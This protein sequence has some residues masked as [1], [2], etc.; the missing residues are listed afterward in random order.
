MTAPFNTVYADGG[1]PITGDGL[2]TFVQVCTN[3]AVARNFIGTQG[4]AMALLGTTNPGDGGSGTFYWNPTGTAADDNGTSTIVPSGSSPG[5]GEWT[6][7]T[8]GTAVSI[9][10][11][12]NIT[13][14]GTITGGHLVSTNDVVANDIAINSLG[15]LYFNGPVTGDGTAFPRI[16][17]NA[18]NMTFQLGSGNGQFTFFN[19]SGVAAAALTQAGNL[20]I[21]GTLTQGSDRS[22]KADIVDSDAGLAHILRLSP[23][24]YHRTATPEREE[25]GLIAQDVQA[26]LPAA[27]RPMDLHAGGEALGI[28]YAAIVAS[29]IGAVKELTERIA[30][31]EQR[32][33]APG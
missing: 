9:D 18:A 26:V 31:L 17:G 4:M 7:A 28:D 27:V 8:T 20:N 19:T 6:R 1:P 2:N 24:R 21:L 12:G 14:L 23:K 33:P 13:T 30:Q 29:L 25:V 16:G 10:S 3:V 15:L 5:S 22:L 11:H 32:T